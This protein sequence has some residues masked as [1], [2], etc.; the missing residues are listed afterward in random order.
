VAS[1]TPKS[2]LVA[3]T[4]WRGLSA[5]IVNAFLA[6]IDFN[7]IRNEEVAPRY[8]NDEDG[9]NNKYHPTSPIK[10]IGL[11]SSIG[12]LRIPLMVHR[13]SPCEVLLCSA[14]R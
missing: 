9:Q 2:L 5:G 13:M 11:A 7:V 12:E 1:A 4:H 14:R 3:C 6:R 8:D 10:P